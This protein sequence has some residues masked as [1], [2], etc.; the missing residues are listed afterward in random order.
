MED[1]A[2][3]V[4]SSNRNASACDQIHA[5]AA[6]ALLKNLFVRLISAFVNEIGEVFELPHREGVEKDIFLKDPQEIES[7]LALVK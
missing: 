5:Y 4:M 2:L 6:I 7:S 1:F 3:C